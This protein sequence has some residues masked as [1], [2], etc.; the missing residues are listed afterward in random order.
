MLSAFIKRQFLI[1]SAFTDSGKERLFVEV[2]RALQKKIYITASKL[3]ILECLGFTREEMQF[4]TL[5]EQES[6]IH[7][8]PMWTL[9]SFKRLKYVSN[10]YAVSVLMS[11]YFVM[12]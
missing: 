9:A 6:Q 1:V 11:K 5:N 12:I 3:S 8:V 10:Q 4:F 2:A 7:V